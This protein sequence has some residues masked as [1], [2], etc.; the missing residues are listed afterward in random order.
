[1]QTLI[2]ILLI[3][4]GIWTFI[5]PK[6]AFDF[7]AKLVKKWGVTMAATP[8]SFKTMKYIGIGA[9]VVGFLLYFS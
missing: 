4:F 5:S 3:G 1:M 2:A 8:K 6:S 9:A 7:K